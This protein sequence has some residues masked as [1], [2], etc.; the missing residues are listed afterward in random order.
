M[1]IAVDPNY[2]IT[3]KAFLEKMKC[4]VGLMI[5]RDV[6]GKKEWKRGRDVL[7]HMT[8]DHHSMSHPVTTPTGHML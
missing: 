7:T 4:D 1:N 3:N 5:D 8:T 6:A 2:I